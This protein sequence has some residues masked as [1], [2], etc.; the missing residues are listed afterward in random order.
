MPGIFRPRQPDEFNEVLIRDVN[1][2]CLAVAE[3]AGRIAE[4][5]TGDRKVAMQAHVA[6]MFHEAGTLIRN[7]RPSPS[8]TAGSSIECCGFD[9][10]NFCDS[11]AGAYLAALWGLPADV[12]RTVANLRNPGETDDTTFTSLTAVH[13]AHACLASR[14]NPSGDPAIGGLDVD[15]LQRINRAD[16]LG[17]WRELC[18]ATKLGEVLQ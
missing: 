17:Q 16:R 10:S 9:S 8:R 3:A 11:L 1:E 4:S 15:Y 14:Q 12:V 2:L 13:V 6:G 7:S 18:H 5:A